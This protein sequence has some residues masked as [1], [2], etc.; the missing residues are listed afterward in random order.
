MSYGVANLQSAALG[1]RGETDIVPYLGFDDHEYSCPNLG[2]GE[3]YGQHQK[4]DLT[5]CRRS[6]ILLEMV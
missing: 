1:V 4:S 5:A 3:R 2:I 6:K